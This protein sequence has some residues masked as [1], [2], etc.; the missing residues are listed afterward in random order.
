MLCSTHAN[1]ALPAV[2]LLHLH[3]VPGTALSKPQPA[4]EG[5]SSHSCTGR[6]ALANDT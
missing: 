4:Q 6:K 5:S 2:S 3:S 1:S